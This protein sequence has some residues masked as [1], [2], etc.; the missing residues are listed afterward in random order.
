MARTFRPCVLT[1]NDLLDGDV[2]YLA[3]DGAWTRRSADARLFDDEEEANRSL[4]MAEA[5]EDAI[6]GRVRRSSGSRT[7][8]HPGGSSRKMRQLAHIAER[9]DKGYGHFTTR[10]NVQFNWPR[11]KDV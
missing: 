4:A 10:Q 8:P 7:G 1:A 9:W 5:Q 11:L 3:L 6:V 2:V